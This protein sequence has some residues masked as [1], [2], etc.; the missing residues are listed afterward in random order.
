[1]NSHNDQLPRWLDSLTGRA[2]HLYPFKPEFSRLSF[3][4]CSSN[5]N[6]RRCPLLLL[7]ILSAHFVWFPVGGAYSYRNICARFKTM[8]RKQNLASA[9]GI[10]KENWGVTTHFSEMI[11]LQLGKERQT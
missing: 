7:R 11:K 10:Q 8:R 9:L 1:M 3:H 2:L 5:V 4:Y 6:Q